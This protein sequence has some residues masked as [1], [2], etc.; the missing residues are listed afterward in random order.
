ML[1]LER[2]CRFLPRYFA[3]P[4]HGLSLPFLLNFP[5][6]DQGSNNKGGQIVSVEWSKSLSVY[7]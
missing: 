3:H 1:D 4:H 2:L 6:E 7:S 5:V